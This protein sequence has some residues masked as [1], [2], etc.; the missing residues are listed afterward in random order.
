[1][2]QFSRLEHVKI[3]PDLL[4]EMVGKIL[5]REE[6]EQLVI[7]S[8]SMDENHKHKVE[9]NE[10]DRTHCVISFIQNTETGRTNLWS[11]SM[12]DSDR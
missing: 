11:Q 2:L 5:Y 1:M 9:L 7:T 12:G 3:D 10:P 8:N 6:N 4:N